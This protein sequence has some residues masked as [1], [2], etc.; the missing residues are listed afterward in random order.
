MKH[1]IRVFA[2]GLGLVAGLAGLPFA[3]Q[4]MDRPITLEE[5]TEMALSSDPRIDEQKANVARAQALIERV[6]GEGGPRLSANLYAGL[7]PQASDGIFTNG[8]NTC[9]DGKDCTLRDDATD[10]DEGVT[11]TT[12]LTATLIQPLYTFGKLENYRKAASLNR[13]V[14]AGE[15]SIARGETWLTVRRAWWGY[16]TAQDTRHMLEG[17]KR[18]VV[19]TRD[20]M[21]DKAEQGEAP[22]SDLY[23]LETGV[24]NLDRYIAQAES[25]ESIALDGLK[26]IIG[27][28]L[29]EPIEVAERGIEPLDPPSAGLNALAGE[30][31]ANRPEMMMAETGQEAV[32]HLISARKSDKY[33]NL[34]AG[35]VAGGAYTPGRERL[36]NPYIH[37]PLNNVF[38]T[39]V[40][41]LQW[42]FNPGLVR[43][44]V[45]EAE[46]RMQE[47]TA[48][49]RLARQG[50]PFQ[51]AEAYH[52]AMGL[53]R[54]IE[55]LGRARNNSRRWMVSSFMDFQ[56]G[57]IDGSKLADAVRANTEAQADYF[58]AINDF[59]M[60]V[61]RLAVATGDYPQ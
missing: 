52:Q 57:L 16:L 2:K 20:R 37:Q 17:V 8:T 5:A 27:L 51:V 39:P 48:K 34:Y 18:Q 22:M 40:I 59:N 15:V 55:A 13:D 35:I 53:D 45:S 33:P 46:A 61:A 19:R 47:V 32:R 3:A 23:A 1:R 25:V 56:A 36:N 11:V 14:S 54:Q 58:R 50:I 4:A 43:A 31:L 21:R 60:S 41:G 10:L 9:P 30:A 6:K 12:G 29:D 26:T 49:A 38:A 42:E 44:G 24:G 7:A 28:P